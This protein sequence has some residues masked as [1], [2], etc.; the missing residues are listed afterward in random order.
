VRIG[1]THQ[2]IDAFFASHAH[3]ARRKERELFR[4][5]PKTPSNSMAQSPSF[6][7]AIQGTLASAVIQQE[8]HKKRY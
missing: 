2:Y 6:L 5:K 3:V 8:G 7:Q 1:K 4:G